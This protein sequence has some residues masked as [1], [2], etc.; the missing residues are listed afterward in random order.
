MMVSTQVICFSLYS[1]IILSRAPKAQVMRGRVDF[2]AR[3]PRSD[4]LFQVFDE[5]FRKPIPIHIVVGVVL[6]QALIL[7][8]M[9]LRIELSVALPI[10]DKD[11]IAVVDVPL[12]V[13][14]DKLSD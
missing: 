4:S 2:K 9:Q 8:N 7:K 12:A 3:G 1:E 10:I 5:F 11:A 6:D 13:E 14:Y